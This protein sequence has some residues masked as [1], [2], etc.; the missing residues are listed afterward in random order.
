MTTATIEQ[1]DLAPATDVVRQAQTLTV[2]DAPSYEQAGGV[3]KAVKAFQREIKEWF[4]PRKSQAKTVHQQYCDDERER[5]APLLKAEAVLKSAMQAFDDQQEMLRRAEQRRL[6]QDARDRE[7]RRRLDEAATLEM[8][9]NATNDPEL[10]YEANELLARPVETP[11]VSVAKA[12]PKVAGVTYRETWKGECT[13]LMQLV[14][15]VAEHPEHLN[16]L[17]ANATAIS[18]LAR[19]QKSGLR[20]PGVRV[21]SQR[22]IAAGGR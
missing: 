17:Q 13:G 18:Q 20:I 19:A 9:G 12:T 10:L 14:Q 16:L 22:D 4:E 11:L 6:E 2:V 5:L 21:W 15:H 8:E 7:E 1:M 3:L